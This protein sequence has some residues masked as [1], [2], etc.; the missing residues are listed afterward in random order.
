MRSVARRVKA[1]AEAVLSPA[2]ESSA[3]SAPEPSAGEEEAPRENTVRQDAQPSEP[4]PAPREAGPVG[5]PGGPPVHWLRDIQALQMGPP[6]DWV[7]RVRRG[8]P[9]LLTRVTRGSIPPL[10]RAP[11]RPGEPQLESRLSEPRSRE[12]VNTERNQV[13]PREPPSRPVVPS[14][15]LRPEQSR[16]PAQAEMF[17]PRAIVRPAL[18]P[19]EIEPERPGVHSGLQ[20]R[21]MPVAAAPRSGEPAQVA[22]SRP[23]FIQPPPR[24]EVTGTAEPRLPETAAPTPL[25]APAPEEAGSWH[26]SSPSTETEAPREPRVVSY[27]WGTEPVARPSS[28]LEQ[29]SADDLSPLIPAPWPELPEESEPKPS[30]KNSSEAAEA[31]ASGPWP[32]LPE[33]PLT[34]SPE[35]SALLLQWERLSRLDREQRGE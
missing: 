19:S 23:E 32:Q 30:P 21:E 24:A 27:P 22:H 18:V 8:A 13:A 16:E 5:T 26:S 20:P 3:S 12:P 2:S 28:T 10:T 17:E 25:R 15:P 6:A 31:R 4:T 11:F 7:A 1:W 34:E 33:T 29:G 9:H 14:E 35:A